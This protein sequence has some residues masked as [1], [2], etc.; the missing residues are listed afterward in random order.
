MS[1]GGSIMGNKGFIALSVLLTVICLILGTILFVMILDED[2][3]ASLFVDEVYFIGRDTGR[4]DMTIDVEVWLT[5]EGK[6]AARTVSVNVFAVETDSNLARAN[7]S[8]NLEGM[9]GKRS[10]KAL[11]SMEV[12]LNDTYRIEVL[13]FKD[14][15]L[16]ITGSGILDLTKAGYPRDYDTDRNLDEEREEKDGGGVSGSVCAVAGITGM[17]ILVL[18]IV[19]LVSLTTK[20]DDEARSGYEVRTGQL[21]R[22]E[23][24]DIKRAAEPN[25][26]RP[27]RPKD[28][29]GLEGDGRSADDGKVNARMPRSLE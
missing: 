28:E 21:R 25:F 14:G 18:V 5:N 23:V 22:P 4:T 6:G 16:T 20:G 12:P 3:E 1:V 17:G 2:E 7:A 15:K 27:E 11:M 9:N 10:S 19:L 13:V 26:E 8:M 24:P 29:R